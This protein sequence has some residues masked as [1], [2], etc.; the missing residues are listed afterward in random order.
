MAPAP[1]LELDGLR[2]DLGGRPVLRGLAGTLDGR[3]V[4]LLGP[5]GAGK[6]TLLATLLGFYPVTAGTARLLGHDIRTERDA[7]RARLGYMPEN[8][9]LRR[10]AFGGAFRAH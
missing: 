3:I 10:R 2:V 5:N 7:I 9:A 4:G 6:T 8:E 1:L